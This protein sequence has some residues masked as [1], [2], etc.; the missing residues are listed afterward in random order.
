[1]SSLGGKNNPRR[2]SGARSSRASSTIFYKLRELDKKIR[3]KDIQIQ[4]WI[5]MGSSKS[6]I[7]KLQQQRI[8][9]DEKRR[10]TRLKRKKYEA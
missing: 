10:Q 2:G 6:S 4:M 9:L 5:N 3:I 7:K 1:M 8:V